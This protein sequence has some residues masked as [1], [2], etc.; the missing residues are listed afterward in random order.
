MLQPIRPYNYTG[1]GFQGERALAVTAVVLTIVSTL[2]LI[3]LTLTQKKHLNNEIKKKN[4]Q[5]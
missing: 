5:Q 1:Q 4:G 2:L 3:D